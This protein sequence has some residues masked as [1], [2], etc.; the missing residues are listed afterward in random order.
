MVL[1]CASFGALSADHIEH[2]DDTGIAAMAAA[3]TVAVLL[4]GAFYFTRDTTLPPIAALRA[5]ACAGAGHRQQPGHFA[6]DQPAAGD[7][8][9]RHP[10][11][12]DR[13][14]VH[15]RLHP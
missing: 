12:P 11:P 10:V 2:L 8:H 15:R 1:N 7:E 14:R 13:G 6:A 5:A 9:G 4:P 3:G